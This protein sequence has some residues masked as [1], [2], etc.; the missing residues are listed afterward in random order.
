MQQIERV[1]RFVMLHD[2]EGKVAGR[3][4]GDTAV[5]GFVPLG[6]FLLTGSGEE[7]GDV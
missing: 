6:E 2:R 1:R 4:G 7:Q 3:C 5:E